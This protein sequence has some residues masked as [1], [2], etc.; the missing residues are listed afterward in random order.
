MET[1][2]RMGMQF[3]DEKCFLHMDLSKYDKLRL[4]VVYGSRYI[5]YCIKIA[6]HNNMNTLFFTDW[7]GR[8]ISDR[9]YN[10]ERLLSAKRV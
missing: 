6:D 1:T 7:H 9:L 8:I 2:V 10:R 4:Y 3:D 5:E